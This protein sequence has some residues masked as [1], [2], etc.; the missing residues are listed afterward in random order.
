MALDC[1]P[2]NRAGSNPK[3]ASLLPRGIFSFPGPSGCLKRE[4]EAKNKVNITMKQV[5]FFTSI[6]TAVGYRTPLVE[7]I[8]PLSLL[9]KADA[10]SKALAKA[11]KIAS[12]MW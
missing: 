11:L 5:F 1:C 6:S 8:A 12:D 10:M 7:G 2:F 3:T 4:H 9:S